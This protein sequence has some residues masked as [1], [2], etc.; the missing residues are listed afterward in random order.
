MNY[1]YV[2]TRIRARKSQLFDVDDYRKLAEMK[3]AAE[4]LAFLSD[5]PYKQDIVDLPG[6]VSNIELLHMSTFRNYGRSVMNIYRMT[7]EGFEGELYPL[8]MKLDMLNMLTVLRGKYGGMPADEIESLLVSSPTIKPHLLLGMYDLSEQEIVASFGENI[9]LGGI[10]DEMGHRE[11]E[12][13][14]FFNW[15]LMLKKLEK[16]RHIQGFVQEALFVYDLL[17][18]V[19]SRVYDTPLREV[20]SEKV[21]RFQGYKHPEELF[22]AVKQAFGLDSS[23]PCDLENQLEARLLRKGLRLM[24]MNPVSAAPIVGY[25]QAKEIE[26]RNLRVIGFGVETGMSPDEIKEE[27]IYESGRGG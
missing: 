23:E 25:L 5:S 7:A 8:F 19:K 21:K 16:V 22:M 2:C 3:D 12:N 26:A 11:I 20:L 13:R 9:L 24:R 27:L 10:E 17:N 15:L 4:I 18:L 14:I 1:P 6:R